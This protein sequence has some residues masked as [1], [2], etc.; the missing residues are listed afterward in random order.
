MMQTYILEPHD[1]EDDVGEGG[2]L[3]DVPNLADSEID[4]DPCSCSKSRSHSR[5]HVDEQLVLLRLWWRD[6]RH[7]FPQRWV[8]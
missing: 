2:D 6:T 7:C 8:G 4:L 5:L 1:G 3:L